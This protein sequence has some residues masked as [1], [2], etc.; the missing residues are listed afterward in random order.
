MLLAA[1]LLLVLAVA[2]AAQAQQGVTLRYNYAAGAVDKYLLKGTL[3]GV[4][5]MPDAGEMPMTAN[6]NGRLTVK[7]AAVSDEGVAS[8][9]MTLERMEV[10]TNAMGMQA[11]MVMEGGKLTVTV[12]GQPVEMP[13]N[14]PGVE[15]IG[16]PIKA[17]VDARGRVLEMD[18]SPLGDL[19]AGFDPTMLQEMSVVFPEGP[20]NVGDNWSNEMKIPLNVMGQKME[21]SLNFTYTFAG[22]QQYKGREVARLDLK[23]TTRMG[24]GG[25]SADQ[26]KQTLSGYELFDCA[27]GRQ[28]YDK[29][30]LE[31]TA[32]DMGAPGQPGA[33]MTMT[34]DFEV[35][36]E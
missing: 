19:A 10:A 32:A 33:T 29:I 2:V 22:V 4:M 3:E 7:T 24:A 17:K 15:A 11:L 30:K 1:G 20:V 14:V 23:G 8:Q 34:G 27:A 21:L 16:K 35:I 9:D 28:V 18:L 31:Q 26:V 12:N 13:Y 25:E 5:K 6:V 36:A